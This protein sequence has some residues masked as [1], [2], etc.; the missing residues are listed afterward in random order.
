VSYNKTHMHIRFKGPPKFF[1]DSTWTSSEAP[2]QRNDRLDVAT[3][4]VKEML[5]ND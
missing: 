3:A 5:S 2:P 1:I 4:A